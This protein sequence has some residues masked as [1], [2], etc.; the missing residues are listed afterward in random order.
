MGISAMSLSRRIAFALL[1]FLLLTGAKSRSV[2]HPANPPPPDVFTYS[3]PWK[4]ATKHVALDLTVDF[5]T[6]RLSGSATL[7]IENFSRAGSL[8]LDTSGLDIHGV[9][10]EGEPASFS[11]GA[12]GDWGRPLSIAIEPA[13][14]FVR[15]D[16]TTSANADGLH[17]NTAA[18]SLGRVMPYL[19]SL[20]EPIGARGWIPIQDTPATRMT[21]SA[22]IR[23]PPGFLALMSAGD[24]PRS[25]SP[26]GVYTFTM[27]Q[28]IPAYL[29]ALAAGRLEYHAFD[30]R[31]GVY[32]EP[33]LMPDAAWELQYLP[34]M[35]AAAER[36]LGPHPFPRHDLLLLPPTSVIGGMEHPMLNFINPFGA[37]TGNRPG[38]PEPS[39]LIAHELAHSWAGD[40]TTLAHWNDVWLN[41]GITSYLAL[42]IIEQMSGMERAEFH[43][44]NDRRSYEGYAAAVPD[45]RLTILHRQVEWPG[46]GFDATSYTKG[47]LFLRMLE[48]RMGRPALDAFLIEYFEM[49][50]FRWVD[51]RSFLSLLRRAARNDDDLMLEEWLY[52]AGVPSNIT[53]P[54]TSEIYERVFERATLFSGGAPMQSLDVASW[55]SLE[56]E[57]FVQIASSRIRSRMSE[58][59]AA[60]EL[61]ARNTPPLAWLN[62]SAASNYQPGFAAVERVLA[63]GGSNGWLMSLYQ[64]LYNNPATRSR[65][66]QWFSTYR[67]RYHP[68]V[69]AFVNQLM[70]EA[71]WSGGLQPAASRFSFHR[72][73]SHMPVATRMINPRAYFSMFST[74][75]RTAS[76]ARPK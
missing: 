20:N 44:F 5:H 47:E 23:V 57:L 18:Q 14:R 59:D 26:S 54:R 10:R 45:P 71:K 15:I 7:E 16:Y 51:D 11:L 38:K 27:T 68:S 42:R 58:V 74:L 40:A 2:R 1:A 55:T 66:V 39:L 60:L 50:S 41:E 32:A 53:A 28:P 21:Y 34:A 52:A 31:T 69:V 36:I 56:T 46:E 12:A 76:M 72:W 29:I 73:Y 67:E 64:A 63:R 6:R 22:T 33:E 17:W 61:S 9:T 19:Y 65:A 48:D 30:E 35:M 49:F 4:V 62:H 3:E 8:V 75:P 37:V 25:T 24:N 13:T 43:F 70:A